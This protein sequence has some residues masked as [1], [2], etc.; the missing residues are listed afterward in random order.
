MISVD[1]KSLVSKADLDFKERL[2]GPNAERGLPVGNGRMGTLLWTAPEQSK[3]HIQVNHTDVFA[4]RNSSASTRR[5]RGDPGHQF[6]CNGCGFVDIDLGENVFTE[7]AVRN[8]LAVY[9]AVAEVAGKGIRTRTFV[10]HRKDVIAVEI[11][12]QR[13][14]PKPIAVDL[15]MLRPPVDIT[16]PHS[17][18]SSLA[19]VG[20]DI[21]LTQ[22]FREKGDRPTALDLNSFTVLRA[23]VIGRA[24]VAAKVDERSIRLTAPA[25]RGPLIVLIALGQSKTETLEQV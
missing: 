19:A 22:E 24:S 14:E 3:L 12:D 7:T 25:G 8:H 4:F 15:R 18:T 23:R 13:S 1:F 16:G 20:Q 11:T 17:A 21:E 2:G 10:W 5:D 9:D 6:Y